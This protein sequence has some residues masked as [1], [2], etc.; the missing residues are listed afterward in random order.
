MEKGYIFLSTVTKN[1]IDKIQNNEIICMIIIITI[2]LWNNNVQMKGITR[3]EKG[4]KYQKV[5][6]IN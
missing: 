5:E 1:T 2:M 4:K 3:N 6:R